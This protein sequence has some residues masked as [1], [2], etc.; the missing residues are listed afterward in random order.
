MRSALV[1]QQQLVFAPD[2]SAQKNSVNLL[3]LFKQIH[4][5]VVIVFLPLN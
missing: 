2:A 5:P 4:F 1:L 3:D